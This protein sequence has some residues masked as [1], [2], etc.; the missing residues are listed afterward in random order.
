MYQI[1]L[2]LYGFCLLIAVTFFQVNALAV[3][4]DEAS[5]LY[6]YK[7]PYLA[8]TTIAIMKGSENPPSSVINDLRLNVIQN[9]NNIY[10]LEGQGMLRYR[11]YQRQAL[12]PLIFIIPGLAGSAYT[13]SATLLAEW[14][15][16]NGFHVIVLPSPFSWNFTLAASVSGFPGDS[17]E[18]TR[19]LYAVLQ[20]VL[21]DVKNKFHAQISKIGIL[22][23]SDGALYTAYLS[24]M[25]LE[26]A[27]IGAEI[28]L[29]IDPP[30]DLFDS[31]RK[32]DQMADLG[33]ELA[34]DKRKYLEDY[35]LSIVGQAL[36]KNVNDPA[37]FADWGKRLKLSDQQMAYLI[38]KTMRDAVGDA[39]YV[40]DL[41]NNESILTEP[42]SWLNRGQRLNEARSLS[43]MSYVETFLLPKLQENGNKTLNLKELDN[44]NSIRSMKSVLE[45]TQSV[46]LMHNRDDILVSEKDID[47]LEQVFADRA[48]I[49]P[50][51]G[52]MG[53]LWYQDNKMH[54]LSVFSPLLQG[55]LP[56]VTQ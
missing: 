42:I 52:H 39:I 48:M 35:G 7:D 31:V 12:A 28:F 43:L 9:R 53:N 21:K 46:F 55:V 3:S 34:V 24:K 40:M 56:P 23:L 26:Q 18:D 5:Y 25:D 36:T 16:E 17:R 22:G 29:L 10:L 47:Y 8:T 45:R 19:D 11:F 32:I 4:V 1:K 6:P 30:V 2:I 33:K 41:V 14:I 49:Y 54:I 38:G 37:Y 51:G 13:G 44:L 20:L 27:R 15:A 50:H